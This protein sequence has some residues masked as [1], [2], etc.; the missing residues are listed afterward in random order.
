MNIEVANLPIPDNKLR[1]FYRGSF[2]INRTRVRDKIPDNEQTVYETFALYFNWAL[3]IED[4]DEREKAIDEREKAMK[5]GEFA[6]QDLQTE[7][8][9][10]TIRVGTPEQKHY[11]GLDIRGKRIDTVEMRRR[12]FGQIVKVLADSRPIKVNAAQN[13]SVE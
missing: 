7:G 6:L 5:E 11:K 3:N 12:V 13:N 4:S 2:G 1:E 8:G 10:L 9:A